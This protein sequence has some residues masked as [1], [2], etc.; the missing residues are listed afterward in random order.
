MTFLELI[1]SRIVLHEK[2]LFLSL[3]LISRPYFLYVFLCFPKPNYAFM[4]FNSFTRSWMIFFCLSHVLFLSFLV[5]SILHILSMYPPHITSVLPSCISHLYVLIPTHKILSFYFV[6]CQN[7]SQKP[8]PIPSK[9]A[10]Q[11]PC[12]KPASRSVIL[13]W[14]W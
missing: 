7:F 12:I 14:S 1:C 4:P 13:S 6:T 3:L 9:L 11:N 10:E 5:I 8:T 2:L